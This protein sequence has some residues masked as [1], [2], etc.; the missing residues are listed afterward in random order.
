MS[1]DRIVPG[2]G[3]GGGGDQCGH[4]RLDGTQV[5]SFKAR[6]YATISLFAVTACTAG[7]LYPN[8]LGPLHNVL[9]K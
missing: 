7:D 6:E 2:K 3:K 9:Y 4:T 1:V 8:L 5:L